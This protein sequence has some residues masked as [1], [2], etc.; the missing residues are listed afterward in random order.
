MGLYVLTL[1]V[2]V[3]Y[4]FRNCDRLHLHHDDFI[5]HVRREDLRCCCEEVCC[6]C[7]C[8][9]EERYYQEAGRSECV[10]RGDDYHGHN[11]PEGEAGLVA[12]CHQ[13]VRV[14][15]VPC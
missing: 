7:R 15:Q 3:L 13:E 10:V 6:C 8:S 12:G 4:I 1:E 14:C 9:Q 2:Q 11:G 5:V